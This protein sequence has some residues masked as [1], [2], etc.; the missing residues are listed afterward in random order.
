MSEDCVFCKIVEKKIPAKLEYEDDLCV[1][2]HDINPRAK[3]HL[4]VIPKK[5]ISTLKDMEKND[6]EIAGRMMMAA[7]EVAAKNDLDSYRLL[8]SVGSE[9]GQEV[10]HLHMHVMSPR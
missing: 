8:V 4:L 7:K 10:F 9:A 2:F 3:V 1:S 5:H 6:A